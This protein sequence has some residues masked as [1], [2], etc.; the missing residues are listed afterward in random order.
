VLESF[1]GSHGL[2]ES[3][4]PNERATSVVRHLLLSH[5][6]VGEVT[7]RIAKKANCCEAFVF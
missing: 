2:I 6:G 5:F 3:S 7:K 1:H 4:R